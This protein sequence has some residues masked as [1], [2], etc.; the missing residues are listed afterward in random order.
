MKEIPPLRTEQVAD[1]AF[2][3]ANPRC[4]N[5][6]EPATGKTPSVCVYMWFLW[7]EHKSRSVWAMPKSLLKKNRDELL[8]FTPFEPEDVVI[9][10]GP[11][12]RREKLMASD[13]KV[14]LMGADCMAR[15]W[16]RLLELHPD[17]ILVAG[18]ETHL[19]WKG[20][21]SGRVQQLYLMMK[22]VPRFIAMTGTLI[23]GKLTSAYPVIHVIEPR[24]YGSARQFYAYH[25]LEDEYGT[26]LCWRNHEKLQRIFARHSIRR[27]F[28]EVYGKESKEVFVERVEMAPKQREMY[29]ELEKTAMLE[30]EDSFLDAGA[31]GVMVVRCRQIMAHPDA[32]PDPTDPEGKRTID[33]KVGVTGKEERLLI[34]LA[35]HANTGKPLVIF[36]TFKRE[37]ARIKELVESQGLTCGL[38]NSTVSAAQRAKVDEGFRHGK[39]QVIVGSPQTASVGFNWQHWGPDRIEVDH[40]IFASLDYEDVNFL[41]AYR[42]AMRDVRKTPLRITVLEYENSIDQRIF[43]IVKQK[44]VEANKVDPTRQILDF[45][46]TV[47]GPSELESLHE[48]YA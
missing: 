1:L 22:K 9:V 33:L 35:D 12:K 32:I 42:R 4:A 15:N 24:Y 18:D 5:L 47:K 10:D 45:R 37:M 36:G 31:P 3:I 14:F 48:H 29:D 16:E 25:A 38:I 8:R 20:T 13:G 11:P 46:A 23:A 17:I 41:Q 26:F 34:H 39:I 30:L 7:N 28:E 44:S 27:T 2:Y 21:E 40:I 6:S 43:Q 19:Y